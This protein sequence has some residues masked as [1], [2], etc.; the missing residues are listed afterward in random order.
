MAFDF[1]E[2]DPNKPGFRHVRPV[3]IDQLQNQKA[4]G[5]VGVVLGS[6]NDWPKV[7]AGA[8]ML[9]RLEIEAEVA[10]CSAHRT[11]GV[12]AEYA[13]RASIRG[14]K[15]IIAVA[16][17]SAHLPAMTAA[18]ADGVVVL[19]VGVTSASFGPMDVI[20]SNVRLP[21][22][23]PAPLVGLDR[24]GAINAAMTAGNILA[25]S[26]TELRERLKAFQEMVRNSVRADVAFENEGENDE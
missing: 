9:E 11:P 16:G 19:G 12:M 23:A 20:G 4:Q 5:C 10:I 13:S 25:V 8:Q 21:S 17:G 14:L 26:D 2:I 22:F 6:K 15:I 18:F 24:A 7:I 3:T 1:L